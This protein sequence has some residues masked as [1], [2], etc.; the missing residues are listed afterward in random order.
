MRLCREECCLCN[1][2]FEGSH[3]ELMDREGRR[4]DVS[5]SKLFSVAIECWLPYS[6]MDAKLQGSTPRATQKEGRRSY[7]SQRI[8]Y[9]LRHLHYA[10]GGNPFEQQGSVRASHPCIKQRN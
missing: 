1:K 6:L 4:K 5:V 3:D 9:A 2:A 8:R 7:N 10:D